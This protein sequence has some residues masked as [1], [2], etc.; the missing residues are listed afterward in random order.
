MALAVGRPCA[1]A[2]G[3]QFIH[4]SVGT[5]LLSLSLSR[6]ECHGRASGFL[7]GKPPFLSRSPRG[8]PRECSPQASGNDASLAGIRTDG[9]GLVFSP[10][11]QVV[12]SV[13]AWVS[14]FALLTVL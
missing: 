11:G 13:P 2:Q 3:G 8:S 7:P 1:L 14:Y 4:P 5:Q 9:A 10:E 12:C 6:A